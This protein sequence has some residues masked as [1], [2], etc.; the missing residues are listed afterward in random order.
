MVEEGTEEENSKVVMV[1][2]FVFVVLLAGFLYGMMLLLEMK[3]RKERIRHRD[4]ALR[5][6]KSATGRQGDES[7]VESEQPPSDP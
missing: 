5:N 6:R 1:M 4:E 3:D 7:N 2:C